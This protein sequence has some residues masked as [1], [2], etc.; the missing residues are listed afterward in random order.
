MTTGTVMQ[1]EPSAEAIR[2]ARRLDWLTR[3]ARATQRTLLELR[4]PAGPDATRLRAQLAQLVVEI[5]RLTAVRAQQ[6]ARGEAREWIPDDFQPG[7][8]IRDRGHWA[9]VEQV[10]PTELVIRPD[11]RP[12]HTATIPLYVVEAHERRA[13]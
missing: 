7:D 6:I 3:Q 2:V 4:D 11:A 12:D 5:G 9:T 1:D 8:R 13:A 10:T